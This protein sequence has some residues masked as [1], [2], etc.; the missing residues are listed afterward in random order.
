[1]INKKN[2]YILWLVSLL[3]IWG[4]VSL[5][6]SWNTWS[7]NSKNTKIER[8]KNNSNSWL[9]FWSGT[10]LEKNLF[11]KEKWCWCWKK[12]EKW[13][14]WERNENWS[15]GLIWNENFWFKWMPWFID[16]TSDEKTKLENM[17]NDEKKVFFDSKKLENDK[18]IESRE[19]VIDK[20]LN[21]T[22]LTSEEELIKQEII[23]QRNE[24]KTKKVEMEEMRK[25]MEKVKNWETLTNEEQTKVNEFQ[26]K[27]P[28]KWNRFN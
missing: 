12:M 3:T 25:L 20:L 18:K 21:G 26:S 1:M 9:T 4:T 17:T 5:A 10:N 24:M 14:K 15:W 7:L 22:T 8:M 28:K 23:T 6:Y 19:L 16:L 2:A 27:F 13:F 11:W